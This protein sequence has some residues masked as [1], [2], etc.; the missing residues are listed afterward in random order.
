MQLTH[1]T[2][3]VFAKYPGASVLKGRANSTNVSEKKYGFFSDDLA[4]FKRI[5]AGTGLVKKANGA[6]SRHPLAFLMEAADDIC[7]RIIDLEDGYRVG[8]VSFDETELLL[9]PIAF[10]SQVAS[11]DPSYRAIGDRRNQVEYLRARAI[12]KMIYAVIDAFKT[13][14]PAIMRG[15]F[16][17]DLVSSCAFAAQAARI[18]ELSLEKIYSSPQVVQIEAAGFEVMSGLLSTF[19]PALLRRSRRLSL[20]EKKVLELV[21][22]QFREASSAYKALLAATD[23]IS[24]MTDSY[25]VTL[26]RRLKGMELPRG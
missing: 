15:R 19:V 1:A 12:N 14:Y 23:H 22:P 20:A 10:P 21:P 6:W 9:A 16:E 25:A 13:N 2:L 3:A 17:S 26:F 5:A 24:G 18:K 4:A 8:R 7:Y 11:T